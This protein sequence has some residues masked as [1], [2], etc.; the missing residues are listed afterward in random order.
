MGSDNRVAILAIFIVFIVILIILA[1]SG[2][3]YYKTVVLENKGKKKKTSITSKSKVYPSY[4]EPKSYIVP[5]SSAVHSQS[6]DT[7][8]DILR[9]TRFE[10][11]EC[12]SDTQCSGGMVCTKPMIYRMKNFNND[13]SSDLS[14]ETFI[15]FASEYMKENGV[16]DVI[17]FNGNMVSILEDGRIYVLNDR[18]STTVSTNGYSFTDLGIENGTIY[19]LSNKTV[20]YLHMNTFSTNKWSWGIV[21]DLPDNILNIDNPRDQSIL[22]AVGPEYSYTIEGGSILHRVKSTGYR[23]FG[24]TKD[25]YALV[26]GDNSALLVPTGREIDEVAGITLASNNKVYA[27][28]NRGKNGNRVNHMKTFMEEPIIVTNRTCEIKNGYEFTV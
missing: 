2:G 15:P 22:F 21:R 4:E 19:A 16:K 10:G 25:K 9:G 1:C 6:T 24:G 27:V 5:V 17:E 26:S 28:R 14:G 18:G 23:I 12:K 11:D 20:Y 13:V 8:S 3:I 7:Y